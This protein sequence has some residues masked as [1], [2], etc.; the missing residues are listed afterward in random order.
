MIATYDREESSLN[1][2]LNK[3]LYST[4]KQLKNENDQFYQ[5]QTSLII[6]SMLCKTNNFTFNSVLPLFEAIGYLTYYLCLMKS[7][8]CKDLENL[9]EQ[10]FL[11]MMNNQSDLLNFSFQLLSI[12]LQFNPGRMDLY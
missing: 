7:N 6:K 4:I 3:L 8:N 1:S 5:K 12:F 2:S 9:T 11:Q 10:Y